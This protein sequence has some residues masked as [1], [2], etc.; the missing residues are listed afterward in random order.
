MIGKVLA[1]LF[2]RVFDGENKER[3]PACRIAAIKHHALGVVERRSV[4]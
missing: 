4:A 3:I 1:R 2:E